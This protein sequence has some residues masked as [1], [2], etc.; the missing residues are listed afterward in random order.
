MPRGVRVPLRDEDTRLHT[1][2]IQ[3]LDDAGNVVAEETSSVVAIQDA[4]Q[5]LRMW[6]L[7]ER[8]H[9]FE[10][11]SSLALAASR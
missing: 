3:T 2:T 11:A 10:E 8:G 9:S 7:M 4:D 1:V 6:D 5:M